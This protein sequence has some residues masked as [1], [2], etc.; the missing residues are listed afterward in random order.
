MSNLSRIYHT[1][2]IEDVTHRLPAKIRNH[3]AILT[4]KDSGDMIHYTLINNRIGFKQTFRQS[5][6]NEVGAPIS[7][8]LDYYCAVCDIPKI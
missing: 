7:G 3:G 2:T 4:L 8:F 6:L 5:K 1:S